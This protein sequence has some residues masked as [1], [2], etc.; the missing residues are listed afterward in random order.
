MGAMTSFTAVPEVRRNSAADVLQHLVREVSTAVPAGGKLPPERRLAEMLGVSRS[1]LREAIRCLDLLGFLDVRQGDGTYLSSS[2]TH[3]L[4]QAVSWGVL[5]GSVEAQQLVEA[6]RHLEGALVRLAAERITPDECAELRHHVAEMAAA[7]PADSFAAAD[8]AFHLTIARAARNVV[9]SATLENTKSLLHAWVVRVI[10]TAVDRER[11][12]TQHT[13][14]AD[15]LDAGDPHAAG[16]A[17]DAHIA[18]VTLLLQ[19]SLAAAN[20]TPAPPG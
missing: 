17:M 20:A 14:I 13:A 11:V 12:L 18:E 15:A 4:T 10:D 19:Q 2:P 9:L 8:S 1:Q 6:R 16:Q 7:G 5:L 3:L